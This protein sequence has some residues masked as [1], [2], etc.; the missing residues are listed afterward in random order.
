MRVSDDGSDNVV[1]DPCV[2][3]GLAGIRERVRLLGGTLKAGPTPTGGFC[4][5]AVI[6]TEPP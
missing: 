5:R 4:V 3:H 2:G 6:R 1:A